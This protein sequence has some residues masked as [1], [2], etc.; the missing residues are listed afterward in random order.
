MF[1]YERNRASG[2]LI[3]RIVIVII[4]VIIIFYLYFLPS[5]VEEEIFIPD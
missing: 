5:I 1:K 2:I 4:D 3:A